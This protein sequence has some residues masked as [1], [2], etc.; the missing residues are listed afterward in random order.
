MDEL[1]S[2][3]RRNLDHSDSRD[4]LGAVPDG[5]SA[6]PDPLRSAWHGTAPELVDDSRTR[7]SSGRSAAR[8]VR[9]IIETVLLAALI[10]FGVRLLVL[11]FKVDG[12]SMMPNLHNNELL[13]VNRNAYED[14]DLNHWLNKL[15]F[16][17]RDGTWVIYEFDPPKRGDI[18]VFNPPNGDDKPYIKRVIATAGETV[19]AKDG[20]VYVNG[21]KL[22]EP[23]IRAGITECGTTPNGDPQPCPPV[24]VPEGDVFVLGDNRRNSSDSRVFGPVPI[25]NIIGKA[26]VT[27][28]PLEDV[29]RVPHYNYPDFTK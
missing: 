7:A 19:E 25:R 8:A 10:F 4:E 27:Y 21:I 14:V 28:W 22:D 2:Q 29:G 5:Y 26:I 9:E 17:D 13:L 15:P 16:V 18:I 23:Y 24:T 1:P 20:F 11:N 3:S 12:L 6:G